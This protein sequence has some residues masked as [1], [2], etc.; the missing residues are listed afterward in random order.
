MVYCLCYSLEGEAAL[1]KAFEGN[2]PEGI[3]RSSDARRSG[4][5]A[6]RR[7]CMTSLGPPDA[8]GLLQQ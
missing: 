3:A 8:P 5:Q 1:V 4:H 6:T 2:C 7:A